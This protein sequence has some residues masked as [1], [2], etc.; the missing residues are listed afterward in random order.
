M[1]CK[2]LISKQYMFSAIYNTFT[3]LDAIASL[4][5]GVDVTGLLFG[6]EVS[7]N[8][9][10]SCLHQEQQNRKT[11]EIQ[12]NRKTTGQRVNKIE[13]QQDRETKRQKDNRTERQQDRKITGQKDN[14][15][16]RQQDRETTRQKDNRTE[17]QQNRIVKWASRAHG[18]TQ[19]KW[20]E[21]EQEDNRT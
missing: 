16:K 5:S 9:T 13:I 20:H 3:F 1:R 12:Q 17:R 21:L 2:D 14:R 6:S 8:I 10:K 11:T 15:T 18:M 7:S 19:D 4:A